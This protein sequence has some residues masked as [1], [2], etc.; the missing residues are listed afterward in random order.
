MESLWIAKTGMEAT[1][2]RMDTISNNIA[3]L[4]TTGFKSSRMVFQDLLYQ[5]L[6][7]PGAQSSQQTQ[8]PSGL[9]VGTGVQSVASVRNFAPG[10]LEQTSNSL[11]MAINGPGFFQVLLP[12]GTT[13]YSRDGTFQLDSQGQVVTS[14][15]YAIQPA[16]TIPAN[17]TRITIAVDGT[18]SALISG[19]TTP[20]QVGSVQ[21]AN[22]INPA[23]LQARGE[24]LYIET[25]S[26]GTPSTGTPGSTGLGTINQGFLESSNV[27]ATQE[28]VDMIASQRIF[29]LNSRSI[30]TSDQMLQR[31]AQL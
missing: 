15:G 16:L 10:G 9:Q 20:T 21:L 18:V 25:A 28:L 7:Q 26:S 30:Q 19:T 31:L 4:S 8:V 22:F 2:R 23:G 6:R 17:T 14:S 27:N 12:D 3:N 1:Q 24:N 5:T 11:D 29:E 13:A